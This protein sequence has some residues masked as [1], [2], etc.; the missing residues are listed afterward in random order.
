MIKA[1]RNNEVR[2]FPGL[3]ISKTKDCL[4]VVNKMWI[5]YYSVDVNL[6]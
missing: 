1:Y 3:D 4:K 5:K 2:E 6:Y